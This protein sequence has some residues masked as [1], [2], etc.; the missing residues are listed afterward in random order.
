MNKNDILT[1]YFLKLLKLAE[2][3]MDLLQLQ[4]GSLEDSTPGKNGK[5]Y[6]IIDMIEW[7]KK[8]IRLNTKLIIFEYAYLWLGREYQRWERYRRTM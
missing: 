3:K 2:K 6:Y 8:T 4:L 7:R 5:S 1:K